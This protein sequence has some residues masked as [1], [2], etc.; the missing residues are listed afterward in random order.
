MFDLEKAIA[1]WRKTLISNPSLEPGFIAEIE[2]HLRDRIDGFIARGRTPEQAFGESIKVLGESGIIGSEFHKVYTSRRGSRPSWQAPRFVPGLAWNYFRTATRAIRRNKSFSTINIAGLGLGMLCFLLIMAWVRNELSFDHFHVN[3]KD[4]YMILS[5]A[6]EGRSWSTTTYALPPVLDA[7]YPEVTDFARVWP[8]HASLVKNGNIRFQEDAITLTDPGF[9][10]MFT[11]PFVRGNPETAL[12]ERN[13]L[14]L[15]EDAARRYFGAE[16]PV[17]KTLFLAEPGLDF[18]VTAVVKNVPQNSSLR[19]DMVTRVEWLG[20]DRLARWGEFVAYAYVRLRPG[21]AVEDFNKKI[22]GIFQEHIN[23]TYP[24]KPF[25]QPFSESYLYRDGRPGNIRRVVLFSSIAVLILL[26]ACVNFLNLSTIQSAQRTR[27]VGLRKSIG[28][29]RGQII[30]QFLGES[31]STSFLAMALAVGAAP[32]LLPSFNRLAGTNLVLFG[33]NIG[34]LVLLL[35]LAALVVGLAAG[36]YPAF[37]L[38]SLKLVQLVRHR[39]TPAAGGGAF[40][41]ILIII[42]FSTSVALILC[43]IIIARQLR[44]LRAF[45]LGFN[46]DQIVTVYCNP[47]LLSRF[48][49]FKEQLRGH[50]GVLQ[51][52]RAAQRPLDVGQTIGVDW[53]GNPD[54][55]P[56]RIGYT[57]IDVDFFETFEMPIVRGRSLSAAFPQDETESCIVNEAAARMFGG[58]DPIGRMLYWSQGAID[59]NLRNVRIVGVVKDFYDRSLREGIR[60]FMF[61]KYVP[62]LQFAFIKVDKNRISEVLP[63]VREAFEKFSP[64]YIF[65]YEFLDDAFNRQYRNETQQGRL[66]NVFS[67]LAIVIAALG[68][69][70]LAGFTAQKRTKEISIRKVLGASVSE[71]V[72]LLAKEYLVWIAVANAAA[73]TVA[74]FFLRQWLNQ[75]AERVELDPLVFPLASLSMLV[76]V[77]SVAGFQTVRAARA[78][79]ADALRVD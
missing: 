36:S 29:G 3:R 66:F 52:T 75:F 11:F 15:T 71:L 33:P 50:P 7:E 57:M 64:E 41:K 78:N 67:L 4:L 30:R 16:N 22:S 8:W 49:S 70:G 6:P 60:P 48:D 55:Q 56:A 65:S 17:G 21:V 62:W 9:F 34:G 44:F 59:P 46:R 28:A 24:V 53:D 40:R 79:P 18:Q 26:M 43:A 37:Y 20:E 51:V 58:G 10:R 1:D 13:S 5:Q 25:L 77:L 61:R 73:W 45:D 69:F 38:S 35:V 23:Q 76:V 39:F 74:F 72:V 47:Q 68:L 2:S 54:P 27:E 32:L 31:L 19:F 42:Q 14:V 63:A 12:Q